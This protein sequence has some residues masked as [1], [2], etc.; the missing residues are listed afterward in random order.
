M[1]ELNV[2]KSS[3]FLLGRKCD[4]NNKIYGIKVGGGFDNSFTKVQNAKN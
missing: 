1:F 3:H 4:F 2:V